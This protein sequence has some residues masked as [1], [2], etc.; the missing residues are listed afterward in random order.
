MVN[1][2]FPKFGM[3]QAGAYVA[4]LKNYNL[5]DFILE[6]VAK[7]CKSELLERG[8][9]VGCR[10]SFWKV[11]QRMRSCCG[12]YSFDYSLTYINNFLVTFR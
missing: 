6:L 7:D 11:L 2:G 8:R 9:I 12:P 3:S 1:K 4:A 10:R 5:P